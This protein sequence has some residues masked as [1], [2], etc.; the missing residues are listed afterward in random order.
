[1]S[2]RRKFG[3]GE[4]S[5]LVAQ[6]IE[7][8]RRWGLPAR[9]WDLLA[10]QWRLPLVLTLSAVA[11]AAAISASALMLVSHESHE[12]AAQ[13]SEVMLSDVRS[14]MTMFTS[15]DPFH[16]NEYAARVEA[17]ATGEFARQYHEKENDILIQVSGAEPTTG[18]VLDA[19][20]SRWNDDG[21]VNVMVVTQITSKSSDGERVVS[22]A[23]RW[24]V[25]AMQ[26]G[27]EWKISSLLPVI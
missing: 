16:A 4:T 17:H 14:F 10:R 26:E 7:P 13:K 18:T 1:M 8:P 27:N 5:L 2:P 21:S 24:L 23:N 15:P 19:G 11:A 12:R 6:P 9:P 22:T 25:T 20:V 3:P